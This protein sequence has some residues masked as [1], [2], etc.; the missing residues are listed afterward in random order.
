MDQ[1]EK[2][3]CEYKG[4]VERFVKFKMP[5][6][7]DADDILQEVFMAANR[8][9]DKLSDKSNFKA[10][11]IGIARNKCNDYYR[12]KAKS[13]EIPLEEIAGTT[14]SYSRFGITE[15]SIVRETL[16]SLADKDKEVL[17]LYF[18]RDIPQTE[19]AK[20]L[21]IPLG[22]VKSRLY[23]AKQNFKEKY[24][25]PPKPKG[26]F[27]MKKLP[28]IMSKY[29]IKKSEKQ[30]F[31]VIWEELMGWFLVPKLGE[32]LS[33][34]LYDMPERKLTEWDEMEVIGKAEVHA[35]KG[36]EITVKTNNPMECNS[37]GGQKNVSRTFVAQLTDTH[38]RYL[39]E[40]HIKDGVKQI[41]TF[42]DGDSFLGNWGFGEN[43]CGNETHISPKGDIVRKENTIT[44]ATKPFLLD[45]VGR[46]YVTI[47]G[48]EYDTICIMDIET[49][50]LGVVSEQY[51]DKNGRTILW[52]RFNRDDWAY[53]HY[54][55]KWSEKLPNNERITVNGETY[56]HWY[57]CITDYI[58]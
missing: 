15:T 55:Q 25:Y 44:T 9:F 29:T 28:S 2:L 11:I 46:F 3:L 35:I 30:P 49:Y 23:T 7:F 1:F 16:S 19:I 37:E 17:Y 54:K 31:S 5:S 41:Y 4:A 43:N 14:L 10:W 40:S 18:F 33:W 8:N 58:L 6:S 42:L 34:G 57:D 12:F 26:E 45:I 51:L 53:N 48:K 52:R 22:T 56:V 13:M 36:V 21:N 39:A 50:N 27:N 38:C 47:G 24:P 32:K 20:K